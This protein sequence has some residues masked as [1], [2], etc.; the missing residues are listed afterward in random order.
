M[1]AWLLV[2]V[3]GCT[4]NFGA[5]D[6]V[7]GSTSGDGSASDASK[8]AST[9]SAPTDSMSASDALVCTE[10]GA[11]MFGGHC[12]FLVTNA[13]NAASAQSACMAASNAHL[14][15]ITGT[16]EETAVIALGAGTERWIGLFRM[17]GAAMDGNYNWITGEPRAGF[18]DWSPGEP[19][20]SGQCVRLI[21][22]GLWA[23]DDCGN[24]HPYICERE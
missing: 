10:S 17:N 8:D 21:A 3:C 5:F 16:A 13:T 1:R 14:V 7:D 19:N 6:P 23:D 22:T 12:Y 24:T 20:G 11:I 18:S 15:T 9:D 4:Q 2:V